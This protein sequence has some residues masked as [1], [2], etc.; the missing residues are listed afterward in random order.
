MSAVTTTTVV[1]PG[2][3]LAEGEPDQTAHALAVGA[4]LEDLQVGEQALG[5]AGRPGLV[6]AG[7]R[8]A[9]EREDPGVRAV[10]L[11]ELGEDGVHQLRVR[12]VP[13]EQLAEGVLDLQRGAAGAVVHRQVDGGAEG[14]LHAVAAVLDDRRG[15]AVR[16]ERVAGIG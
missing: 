5:G 4:F 2:R 14:A 15:Q 10:N 12:A 11:V 1:V 6:V 7:G 16:L 9:V 13:P 3:P 8:H